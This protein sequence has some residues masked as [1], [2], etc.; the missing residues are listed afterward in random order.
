[1]L[2]AGLPAPNTHPTSNGES[3]TNG[4]RDP[5]AGPDCITHGFADTD[6]SPH[7]DA[8]T[9]GYTNTRTGTD[10]DTHSTAGSNTHRDSNATATNIN[11][12]VD[13]DAGANDLPRNRSTALCLGPI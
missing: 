12:S 8:G 4:D 13:T 6:T 7:R 1:M 3:H 2:P 11:A 9:D 10:I 5:H